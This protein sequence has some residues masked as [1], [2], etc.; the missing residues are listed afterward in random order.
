MKT[1]RAL[2][3]IV[4]ILSLL[5]LLCLL[6]AVAFVAL[7]MMFPN[8][9]DAATIYDAI[10]VGFERIASTLGLG[11][12]AFI[13]PLLA[14]VLPAQ[15]LL[16]AVILLFLHDNGKQ[17]KYIAGNILSLIGVALMTIFTIVFANE[18]VFK[19][20]QSAVTALSFSWIVRLAAA[21]LLAIFIIF[22][23]SAL[24]VKPKKQ[25]SETVAEELV[26]TEIST[27]GET[28][29]QTVSPANEQQATDAEINMT[30]APTGSSVSDVM[31]GI[32]GGENLSPAA[33]DKIN[34][35]RMLYDMG[36]ITQDEYIKLVNAY[37][38]K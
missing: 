36:A 17:G 26:V 21:G 2:Q 28:A 7:V 19:F 33:M 30:Y 13:L 6:A 15:L 22:I 3:I 16:I 29:Y 25:A 5:V 32:Y 35:A 23:G 1:R 34:K 8:M 18:L 11:G 9:T 38:K 14:Y 10:K 37:T 4:G 20:D 12:I 24:G 31:N 27:D